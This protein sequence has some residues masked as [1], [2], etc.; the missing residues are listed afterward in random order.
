MAEH[1]T[2]LWPYALRLYGREGVSPAC[3]RL[4]D[5]GGLDV[6]E[7]LWLCWLDANGQTL[8][9]RDGEWQEAL[10]DVRAW[11]RDVTVPLRA[12]RRRLKAEVARTPRLATLR[13]HVKHAE[14]EAEKE[15]LTRLEA[16]ARAG[17]GIRAKPAQAPPLEATLARWAGTVAQALRPALAHVAQAARADAEPPG[18]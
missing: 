5:E 18:A 11:Q 8:A 2:E 6:C 12:Q 3:V 7:L 16:L 1:F 4:Q 14:L 17:R 15:A 9:A 10:A 13:G